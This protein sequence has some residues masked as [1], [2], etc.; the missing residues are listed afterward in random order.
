MYTQVTFPD[1]GVGALRKLKSGKNEKKYYMFVAG[2]V[3]AVKY[4]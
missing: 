4:C 2:S 3:C 1:A